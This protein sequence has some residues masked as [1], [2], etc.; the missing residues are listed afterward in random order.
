MVKKSLKK[1]VDLCIRICILFSLNDFINHNLILLDSLPQTCADFFE[2]FKLF[3]L[4]QSLDH[5]K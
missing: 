4:C 3:G 1:P 5:F 2:L